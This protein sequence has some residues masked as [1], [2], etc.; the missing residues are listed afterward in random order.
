[1]TRP[2][3]ARIRSRRCILETLLVDPSLPAAAGTLQAQP[4]S[5]PRPQA[6]ACRPPR[7]TQS[8]TPAH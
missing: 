7:G 5:N 2:A 1:V 3:A 8:C 4:R 6:C